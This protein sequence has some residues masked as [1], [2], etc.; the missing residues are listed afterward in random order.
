MARSKV[1]KANRIVSP[2][3]ACPVCGDR[4]LKS[5]FEVRHITN[6]LLQSDAMEAHVSVAPIVQCCE[7]TFLF[8]GMRPSGAYLDQHYSDAN[9][10]YLK[11]VAEEDAEFRE[12]FRVARQL[13]REAF[14]KGGTILD[15]GCASGFFLESMGEDWHRQGV[16]LFRLAVER[17][18]SR[19]GI[20]VREGDIASAGFDRESFDVVCSFDVLEHLPKPVP[21][22]QEARRILKPGGM[23]LMGTGDSG[24]LAARLAGSRWTYFCIP[25]HLS[26]YN[27]RSLRTGLAKFGFSSFQFKRIHHGLRCRSVATGWLRG[28]GKHWAVT[29]CGENI[30]RA[31]IFRQKTS[32]F[33]VPYFFDHMICVAR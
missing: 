1:S 19:P 31:R 11:S 9:E 8:K 7:C 14:P 13:L 22:F 21:F 26:F 24:S 27:P 16:E 15:V 12:D 4:R 17:S 20:L 5:R 33:L 3:G 18:R 2:Y 32:E 6:R 30:V 28:V 10:D 25:E 29:V 23:L